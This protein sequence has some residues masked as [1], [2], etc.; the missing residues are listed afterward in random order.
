MPDET[1]IPPKAPY[2]PYTSFKRF[3]GSLKAGA[4]PSRIDK[5]LMSAQSGSMQSW[6]MS[7]LKFFNFID[8]NGTPLENLS[9]VIE[10]QGDAARKAQWKKAFDR[11]YEPIIS[12]LD[13]QRATIGQ[14]NERFGK[15]FSSETVRKC[16]SFFAAAAEDAGIIL[17]DHLKPK[18]RGT[19]PRKPRKNKPAASS[20]IDP[21]GEHGH[22]NDA[23]SGKGVGATLL[24]T[25]DGARKVTLHSPPTV[26]KSELE[27]IKSWLGFQLIVMEEEK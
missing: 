6:I 8:D 11:A 7:A 23:G 13:L 16:Q 26:T 4:I 12:G 9:L 25:A 5:T 2:L 1:T 3:L 10:A 20:Q 17:A 21:I 27:R 15:D 24:L 22:G 14:L 18:A 19:G